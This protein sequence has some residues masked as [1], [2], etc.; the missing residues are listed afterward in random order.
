MSDTLKLYFAPG[1][2]ARVTL[3]ALE[4]TGEPF[5]TSLVSFMA[6][7]HRSPEYLALNPAGA[8]P[9][10][11]TA[12]GVIT[13]N[14]AIL[15]YLARKYPSANLLPAM[16][17][18]AA[19]AAMISQLGQC[20]SDLHPAVSR[21]AVPFLFAATPQ[22][23]DELRASATERLKFLLAIREDRLGNSDWLLGADWSVLDSYLGWA[24]FRI[25]G[26]GFD[27]S[28][29]PAIAAHYRR[30]HDRPAVQHALARE[31]AAQAELRERGLAVPGVNND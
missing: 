26:A 30:L 9:T 7:D 17:S 27:P 19:E 31:A 29:F 22:A 15:W 20:A 6:G 13:Q 10:L 3:T 21:M 14:S 23:Q 24:W 1:T 18:P 2:C 28:P 16:T 25:T 4:E 8:V 5:E 11:E 12:D